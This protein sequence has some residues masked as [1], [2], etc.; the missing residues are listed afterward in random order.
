MPM[1]PSSVHPDNVESG[2]INTSLCSMNVGFKMKRNNFK[3]VTLKILFY[4]FSLG[5]K[6][7]TAAAALNTKGD[8]NI[9]IPISCML[10]FNKLL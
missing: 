9:K 1:D 4:F 3:Q 2:K 7:R 5:K 10:Q 6:K 8:L